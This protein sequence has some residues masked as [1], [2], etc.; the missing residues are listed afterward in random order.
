MK[1][2]MTVE[3]VKKQNQVSSIG[4]RK[5]IC[6]FKKNPFNSVRGLEKLNAIQVALSR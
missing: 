6:K 5:Y 4:D 1:Q 3:M 2:T